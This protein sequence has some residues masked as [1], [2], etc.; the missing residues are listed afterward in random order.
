MENHKNNPTQ[1]QDQTI[2]NALEIG[3]QIQKTQRQLPPHWLWQLQNHGVCGCANPKDSWL[4]LVSGLACLGYSVS[5]CL[6]GEDE[7]FS[8]CDTKRRKQT[9]QSKPKLRPDRYK[10]KS[11]KQILKPIQNK[12]EKPKPILKPNQSEPVQTQSQSKITT[13]TNTNSK[14]K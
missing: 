13:K 9:N 3:K 12:K 4:S 14:T 5:P 11:P 1:S 8:R 10:K 2:K 7:P 6:L